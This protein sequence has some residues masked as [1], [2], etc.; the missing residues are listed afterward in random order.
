MTY[1]FIYQVFQ[2]GMTSGTQLG[3][4]RLMTSEA[5]HVTRTLLLTH[6]GR[7]KMDAISQTTFLRVFSSMKIVIFWLNFHWNMFA[8]VQLTIIQHWFRLWLGADQ[9]I[10]H[11]PN[12]WLLHYRRLYGSLGLNELKHALRPTQNGRYFADDIFN[13]I[14]AANTYQ[15]SC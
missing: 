7:D 11:Y 1:I 12:Q 9:A 6:W 5:L 15:Q 10:S 8:R 4:L 3:H 2:R 14:F 13:C